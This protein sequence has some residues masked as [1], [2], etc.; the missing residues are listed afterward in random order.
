V[1]DIPDEAF[2]EAVRRTPGVSYRPGAW[3]MRWD[4]QDTLEAQLGPIPG[5]LFLAKAARLIH[6]GLLG[7]CPC[8][9]R[10]D[11]HLP[12]DCSDPTCCGPATRAG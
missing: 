12:A 7:G 5:N 10:G 2:L 6:R 9:C 8:G 1:Q 11:Y 3:R 4:V